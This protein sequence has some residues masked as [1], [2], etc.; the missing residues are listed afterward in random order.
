MNYKHMPT[1]SV[2][3]VLRQKFL[4]AT[5]CH[6]W[7]I[8]VLF[9]LHHSNFFMTGYHSLNVSSNIQLFNGFQALKYLSSNDIFLVCNLDTPETFLI[10][11][12]STRQTPSK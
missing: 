6:F 3:E 11:P 2:Q 5:S 7:P 1:E 10:K 12:Q 4:A 8:W 9:A